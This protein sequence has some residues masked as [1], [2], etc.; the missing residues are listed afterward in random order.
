MARDSVVD[1]L[2]KIVAL[3]EAALAD[4]EGQ[5]SVDRPQLSQKKKSSRAISTSFPDHL[6]RLRDEGY[7]S[8]PKTPKKAHSK[9]SETYPCDLNRVVVALLRVKKRRLLRRIGSDKRVAY[10]W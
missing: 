7:F 4:A 1:S 5:T 2:R 3:A 8:A 10:V 9:I 6:I